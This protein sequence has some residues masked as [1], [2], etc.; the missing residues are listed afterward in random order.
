VTREGQSHSDYFP[1]AVYGGKRQALIA[2]RRYRDEILSRIEP[3]T[4]V[5]RK[6]PRDSRNQTGHVGVELEEYEVDGRYYERYVAHWRDADGRP[7]RSRY[8]VGRYG[9]D[10]A[11]ELAVRTREGGVAQARAILRD[12]QR[13]E[14]QERLADAPPRPP[15][16]KNPLSRKGIRMPPRKEPRNR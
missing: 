11:L 1:D 8:S 3:D 15:R 14:A 5:R 12:R 4:R 10:G 6:P 2:A 9:K 16:V 7:R 13:A